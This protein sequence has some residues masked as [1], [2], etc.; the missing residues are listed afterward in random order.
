MTLVTSSYQ[1]LPMVMPC[2]CVQS[3]SS[4][5]MSRE[6][7][8]IL[9]ARMILVGVSAVFVRALR[10]ESWGVRDAIVAVVDCDAVHVHILPA[11]V[12]LASLENAAQF[13]ATIVRLTWLHIGSIPSVFGVP[14]SP[15]SLAW[16]VVFATT[17]PFECT[18]TMHQNAVASRCSESIVKSAAHEAQR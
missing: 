1:M 2:E 5:R 11:R 18:G 15:L 3:R 16:I 10:R 17:T 9:C 12:P 13:P 7:D 14:P 4:T 6:P 8:L